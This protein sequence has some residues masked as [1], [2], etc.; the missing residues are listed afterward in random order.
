MLC[1]LRQRC[2]PLIQRIEQTGELDEDGADAL[3][4][5]IDQWLADKQR[6]QENAAETGGAV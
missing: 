3:G 4:A 5:H 2:L 6:E 1:Y